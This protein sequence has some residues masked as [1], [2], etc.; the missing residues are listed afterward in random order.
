M[1]VPGDRAEGRGHKPVLFA[2]RCRNG[3]E[4]AGRPVAEFSMNGYDILDCDGAVLR[5]LECLL[6][7]IL[8][9]YPAPN[10]LLVPVDIFARGKAG[11]MLVRILDI[12]LIGAS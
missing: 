5:T 3:R 7:G 4:I 8:V 11:A 2:C 6:D 10:Q 12:A 1:L 9:D